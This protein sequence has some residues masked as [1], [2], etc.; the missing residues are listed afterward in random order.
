MPRQELK[1][2]RLPVACFAP[3][4][5]DE[6]LAKYRADTDALPIGPVKDIC[7]EC[8]LGIEAWYRLPES[9]QEAI[10]RFRIKHKGVDQT[11]SVIPL[12]HEHVNLLWDLIPWDYELDAMERVLDNLPD[13]TQEYTEVVSVD[14][15]GKTATRSA[16]RIVDQA[17]FDLKKM[18]RH[19]IWY[20]RELCLDREPLT[21]DKL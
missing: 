2:D 11:F 12:E 19:L 1:T 15:T 20:A 17:A 7:N 16:V 21:H 5:T 13:G 10:E 3:P 4:L 18:S 6:L 14:G 8:L 9:T